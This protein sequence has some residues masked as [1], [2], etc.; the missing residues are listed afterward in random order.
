MALLVM[1]QKLGQTRMNSYTLPKC[2][3]VWKSEVGA[4]S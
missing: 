1:L 2:Q 3:W 4:L